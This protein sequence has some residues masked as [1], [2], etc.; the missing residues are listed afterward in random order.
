[1]QTVCVQFPHRGADKSD[2]NAHWWLQPNMETIGAVQR[3]KSSCGWQQNA[4]AP[5]SLLQCFSPLRFASFSHSDTTFLGQTGPLW[6]RLSNGTGAR[7]P[8]TAKPVPKRKCHVSSR[9]RRIASA[10]HTHDTAGQL[11]LGDDAVGAVVAP[12]ECVPV[13]D[14]IFGHARQEKASSLTAHSINPLKR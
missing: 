4:L 7:L 5:N 10:A 8:L 6:S 3:A 12:D 11:L 9:Q 2:R 1:M 13:V 14:G